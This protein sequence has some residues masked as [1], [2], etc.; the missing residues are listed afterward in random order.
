MDIYKLSEEDLAPLLAEAIAAKGTVEKW[1]DG[2]LNS[3]KGILLKSPLRYRPYGPYW[4]ALKKVYIDRGDLSL[5]I[6]LTRS[7]CR[8][9]TTASR[10]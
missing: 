9:W 2:Y 4:W 1:M 10:K 6:T 7:G 3:L 5:G 8:Q